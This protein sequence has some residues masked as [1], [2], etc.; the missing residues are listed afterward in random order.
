MNKEITLAIGG[1]HCATCAQTLR[2]ALTKAKGISSATVNFASEQ[3]VI[4]ADSEC[5]SKDN[6]AALVKSAGF[7]LLGYSEPGTSDMPEIP[8]QNQKPELYKMIVGFS[9]GCILMFFGMK[10]AGLSKWLL[11]AIAIPVFLYTGVSIFSAAL[12]SLKQKNLSMDVMYALGIGSSFAASILN[13]L[14]ILPSHDFMFY[15]TAILLAAF[16]TL[17]RYLESRARRHSSSALR[18]LLGLRPAEAILLRDSIERIVPVSEVVPGDCVRIKPGDKIP[19]DGTI[20]DGEGYVDESMISGESMP[21]LKKNGDMVIGGTINGNSVLTFMATRTGNETLLA[22][23]IDMVQRAQNA[24][25]PIQSLAD[26]AVSWFIPIILVLALCGFAIWFFAVHVPFLFAFS[27]AVSILVIA[28][29]CA[30]GLAT[31][32]AVATGIGRGAELG[33]LFKNGSAIELLEQCTMVVFDKTGTLTVGTPQVTDCLPFGVSIEQLVSLAAS[34]EHHSRHPLAKAVIEYAQRNNYTVQQCTGSTAREGKGISAIID[35]IPVFVGSEMF[36]NE[37]GIFI[38][39]QSKTAADNLAAQAKTLLFVAKQNTCIGI[40]ACADT[41]RESSKHAVE[42]LNT[43]HIDSMMIT[44]DNEHTAQ[45]LALQAGIS[46]VVSNMLPE[47]K[48]QQIQLLQ[49]QGRRVIFAGDGINDAVALAQADIGIAMGSGTDVA[50]E[51]GDIVLMRNNILD[52]P[53]A[54]QLGKRIMKQVRLNLFWAF[55]YNA[56]LVPFAA[57]I[58]YPVMHQLVKPE[59]AGMAMAISSVTVVGLSLLLKRYVPPARSQ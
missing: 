8:A 21:V 27:I 31:P 55:A 9:A 4:V 20:I 48:A 26:R 59:W 45:A 52:I 23:I 16:L 7:S 44:G 3:A 43:M 6:L 11:P 56:T 30:L 1:M 13:T 24:K 38:D 58:L 32:T 49:Q 34:L 17:G 57:G 50:I 14:G 39:T 51:T 41:L 5:V 22:Q 33:I 47:Q 18:A 28:C 29:P 19:V 10:L 40:V 54:I 2:N 25:L 36:L 15:D 12:A 53:A 35:N 46:H 42:Q 37:Q